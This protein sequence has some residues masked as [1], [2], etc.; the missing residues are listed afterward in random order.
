[1]NMPLARTQTQTG[2]SSALAAPPLR[3]GS[4]C[5]AKSPPLTTALASAVWAVAMEELKGAGQLGGVH[6]DHEGQEGHDGHDGHLGHPGHCAESGALA[7]LAA[8]GKPDQPPARTTD[9]MPTRALQGTVPASTK[10][11]VEKGAAPD[12]SFDFA[13]FGDLVRQLRNSSLSSGSEIGEGQGQQDGEPGLGQQ[14][15]S[16]G[17]PADPAAEEKRMEIIAVLGRHENTFK[18]AVDGKG[19]DKLIADKNTPPDLVRALKDMKADP[20]LMAALDKAK[21]GKTDNKFSAE[22]INKLQGNS[23]N[24]AFANQKAQDFENTYIPSDNKD[25]NAKPRPMN[26]NDAQR[27]LF[28]YSDYLPKYVSRE[29]LQKIVDGTAAIGKA[30]PQLVA[31]AK[32]YVDHPEAWQ[33]DMGKGPNESI[34]KDGICNNDAKSMELTADEDKTLKVLDANRKT[35]FDGGNLN[36]SKLKQIAA[37][38]QATQEVRDTAKA[39]LDKKESLLYAMLDNGKHGA[40]GN[41]LNAADD[42][43]ISQGDLDSVLKNHNKT[44]APPEQTEPAAKTAETDKAGK[45]DA[46]AKPVDPSA[47]RATEA[48][49]DMS[50]GESDQPDAK[51]KKGGQLRDIATFFLKAYSAFM[52]AA[53]TVLSVLAKVPG[54]GL[55][56]GPAAMAASGLSGAASVGVAALKGED[57]KKAGEMAVLGWAG[58]GVGLAI[59]GGGKLVTAS[60]KVAAKEGAK[61]GGEL[62]AK[63][64]A[65]AGATEAAKTGAKEAG[66]TAGTQAGKTWGQREI[67][68]GS[69]IRNDVVAK[70]A[71]KGAAK[72]L[73]GSAVSTIADETGL[74][75][76]VTGRAT[77]ELHAQE[78]RHSEAQREEQRERVA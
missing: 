2:S 11:T 59:P 30:P 28:R 21:N 77:N 67:V 40:G 41:L 57:T 38:P 23:A 43:S 5:M 48:A 66:E 10:G 26:N 46:A 45:A 52:N 20:E 29:N 15:Q 71:A 17:A 44:V 27:E 51:K 75:D 56:A 58:T 24:K 31:A 18:K 72:S 55:I 13:G 62:A 69:A 49:Q 3:T 7:D 63:Q 25:P 22:D 34:R 42:R 6:G 8:G 4:P 33:K 47:T 19:I 76:A 61:E 65:T 39:L 73:A 54:L 53:S 64:G 70:E 50:D 16:Q 12:R 35:F 74:T 37:D 60:A 36:D 78:L 14:G 68:S 1:M 32:F 9:H